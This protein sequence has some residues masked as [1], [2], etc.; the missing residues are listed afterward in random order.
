M[1]LLVID[2]QRKSRDTLRDALGRLGMDDVVAVGTVREA[3]QALRSQRDIGAVICEHH[4]GPGTDGQ[5]L[6]EAARGTGLLN[7]AAPWI[8]VSASPLRNEVMAAGDFAP[9]GY[10]VRPLSDQTLGQCIATACARK[11][12]LA[13]LIAADAAR[14]WDGLL[15]Q[16]EELAA[17]EP[18]LRIECL[19]HQAH[20]LMQLGR[21]EDALA[22]CDRA[23]ASDILLPWAR[24][25]RAKAQRALGLVDEARVAITWLVEQHPD[26]LAAHDALLDIAE[27]QGDERAALHIAAALAERAPNA[28]RQVRLGEVAL[29]AGRPDLAV[30]AL[31]QAVARNRQSITR[32][33]REGVL[34]AQALID[35]D[36]PARALV[37]ADDVAQQFPSRE[38]A[39][40]LCKA[41]SAQGLQQT[42]RAEEASALMAEIAASG[43]CE[44]LAD[45]EKLLLAKSALST[46]HQ[47]FGLELVR[48]VARKHSDQPLLL[49]AVQRIAAGDPACVEAVERAGAEIQGLL[50]GIRQAKREGEFARG[51]ELGERALALSG[52]HFAVLIELCTLYLV[53]APRLGHAAEHAGRAKALLERLETLNPEHT[54]VAA[55]RRFYREHMPAG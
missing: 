7:P 8:F 11:R 6:L 25:A 13:P 12:A 50:D 22:A 26:F 10:L 46:G 51:I 40:L 49:A 48:S 15:A 17:R 14:D 41:V 32:S 30:P 5:Q 1:K 35:S 42:G 19:R 36:D 2:R 53:A 43:A 18:A 44:S 4:L 47:A 38:A 21:F 28:R 16:A 20:A 23:L 37:V 34:L 3:L 33:H 31:E 27:E 55:A 45:T 29:Q 54:R 24:L 9:D 39:Q 52:D